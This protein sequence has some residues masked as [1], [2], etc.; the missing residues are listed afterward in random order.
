MLMTQMKGRAIDSPDI[1]MSVNEDLPF[2]NEGLDGSYEFHIEKSCYCLD[3]DLS[4]NEDLPF[5]DEF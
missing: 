3:I 1:D 4:V 2:S 5:S